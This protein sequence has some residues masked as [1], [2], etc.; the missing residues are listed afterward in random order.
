M[1]NTADLAKYRGVVFLSADGVTLNAEQEAAFQSYVNNGGGFVGVHDAAR[2]QSD[3]SW[4]TG[5]IGT[6]PALGLP[7]PEKV[8]ESAVNGENPP[9]ETK[10]KLFDGKNDT[11]WLARTPTGWVTMKLDKPVAVVNYALTSA[12]DSSGRDP[13]DW[14]LQGSQDGETW[15]TLDTRTGETFPSR[16]QTRQFQFTNT[17]AYQHY[18]LE[19]TANSGEPLTQLAELRLFS[20]NPTPPQDSEVQQAVVDVTDRQ[21]PANKGLPLNWTR[22]DQWIN[23]DP[24]PIGKVHTIAQVEEGKYKP[25]LS[26]NG[27][28]HPISWCRD[29]DGGR[30]FYTGMGRTEESY[31]TDTKF[32]SHLL[33]AIEWT[34]GM[35]RGDC[36]ATIASNYTTE[37]LTAQNQAGQLDQ[38]GEPHGL[39]MA[40]DGKAFY[41]GKAACPSGAIAD[42]NNPKVGLGCGTIHQWDPKTKK[43]K[44]LTTLDVMGNRGSGDELV[45]NEE[46]LVGVT[47]D[48]KFEK[49]GW[50]YVYWMPHES[51]DRDKRIGQR[52]VSR[53]TYDFA[54]ESIDQAPARTCCTGTPRSTAAA[55]PVAAWPST[56]T[57]TSTSAPV[58][59]T[60]PAARAVTPGTTGPRTT[61][62]S[63]SRT[64]AAPPATPTTSTARS[65]ASTPSPTAPTP[66]PRA[67]SS[68]RVRPRP[69][70]R[71]M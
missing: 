49:N 69:A 64:P 3:S 29:Y 47:L 61:R 1:F 10:D 32:Q 27:P 45:K 44:L 52:T 57:A 16:F 67:T 71:S 28:F 62:V 9:N 37:R 42:W 51:I 66:S 31:T 2:A 36:Q 30:S 55:T 59:A 48:P 18:R 19:I 6:R 35:V 41:I 54:T 5:L 70:P 25:G 34:T 8:V 39:T 50:I 33:G 14:K 20:A 11:K 22:S 21:H 60:P 23:W 58:T 53:L 63:P 68:R 12:N 15:T 56:R 7:D 4:F 17:T 40:P 43:V 13:K 26:A 65:S 38:I 46:G 24:N